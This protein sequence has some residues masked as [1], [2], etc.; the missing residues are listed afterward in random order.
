MLT[1]LKSE[2]NCN[3]LTH[4]KYSF[5]SYNKKLKNQVEIDTSISYIQK[6][7]RKN[8]NI[9]I[10]LV[11]YKKDLALRQEVAEKY[12]KALGAETSVSQITL[13]H[14]DKEIEYV[15]ENL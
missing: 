5:L 14:T 7:F 3:V 10:N 2:F 15:S 1:K 12:T 8:N 6:Q 13:S 9:D 4:E 11:N